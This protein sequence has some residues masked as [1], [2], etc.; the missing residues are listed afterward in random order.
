MKG[1]YTQKGYDR[2]N[3]SDLSR[4]MEDYL[5]MICRTAKTNEYARINVIAS[6]LNVTPS[7]ASRM[8]AKLR[9]KGFVDFE[10]YGMI[11]PTEKGW[12]MGGYLLR[13]HEILHRFF[14]MVNKSES[15][16][17]LVEQIEHF[18]DPETIDH[19]EQLMQQILTEHRGAYSK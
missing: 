14:C 6:Q 4:A 9:E 15:E 8:V 5:E 1:F 12:K 17:E 2:Q 3:H 10:P 11:R 18:I 7:S 19:L 16:I 13:R